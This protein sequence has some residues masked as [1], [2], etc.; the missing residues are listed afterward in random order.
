VLA[1]QP[2]AIVMVFGPP[3]PSNYVAQ[4]VYDAVQAGVVAAGG[5]SRLLYIDTSPAGEPI[6]TGTGN[7][8]APSG[9]GNGDLYVNADTVHSI[10][11][12]HAFLAQREAQMALRALRNIS[13]L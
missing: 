5:G 9:S 7:V 4:S 6:L 13:G 8:G 12:G 1:R 10:D 3:N 2:G 11:A